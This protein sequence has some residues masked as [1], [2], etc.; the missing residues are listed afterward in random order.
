MSATVKQAS[1]RE[2]MQMPLPEKL[3]LRAA[4]LTI[5]AMSLACWLVAGGLVWILLLWAM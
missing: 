4:A 3:S 2:P 1:G 5:G